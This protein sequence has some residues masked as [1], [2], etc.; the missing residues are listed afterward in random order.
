[1]Q[2]GDRTFRN[3][4]VSA[5]LEAGFSL[6]VYGE[7]WRDYQGP[8]R[9]NLVIH[10]YVTVEESLEELSKARIGLNIMS[11]HKAGMTERIANIMLSG[12]VCLTEETEYLR[13]HMQEGR[14]L[15][16]FEL[17]R[18]EELPGK[19]RNLLEHPELREEIAANAYRRASAEYTWERRARE[20]IALSERDLNNALT[21]M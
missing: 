11:W 6:H 18:L 1:M 4:V 13:D 3:A 16:C 7:S 21:R 9:D 8:G 14:E 20:L 5:V 17:N 19:I 2:G 15:V 12:A 10:P